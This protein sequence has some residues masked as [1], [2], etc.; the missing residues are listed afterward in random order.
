MSVLYYTGRNT[1][2]VIIKAIR[3]L[4]QTITV[5]CMQWCAE[6]IY[7]CLARLRRARCA[8]F[9]THAEFVAASRP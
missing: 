1:S 4:A 8:L 2:V 9:Q 5:A 3:P 7:A 6:A